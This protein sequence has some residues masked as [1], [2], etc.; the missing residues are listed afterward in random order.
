VSDEVDQFTADDVRRGLVRYDDDDDSGTERLD[1]FSFVVC[2]DATCA[3]G[4]VDVTVTVGSTSGRQG[5]A[6]S[7]EVVSGLVVVERTLGSVVLTAEHLNASC[8]NCPPPFRVVYTVISAPRRG[9]LGA[10]GT[11][12]ETVASFSQ[13]DLDLGHV[14][15][16]HAD[17]AHLSDSV[18]LSV[19]VRSRDDD[20]I[21]SSSAVRLDIAIKP[22]GADIAMSVVGDVSVMEGERTFITENQ[23]RVQHG[24]D[25]DD[26]EVVVVRL[27]VHGR[28]QVIGER[29]LRTSTSFLL[30]EVTSCFSNDNEGPH[31]C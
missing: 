22:T 26:V 7:P 4:D 19:A 14:T 24:G 5:P 16:R 3:R 13:R 27:P 11:E 1:R 12:N 20:V 9:H 28:I 18:R 15:Y 6:V 29:E 21:R 30:S 8:A 31:R 10:R 23:L 25:V 17:S 2:V